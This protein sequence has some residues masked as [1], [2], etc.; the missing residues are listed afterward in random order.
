VHKL[1][2]SFKGRIQKVFLPKGITCSIGRA[3]DCDISIDNLAVEPLHA[4]IHLYEH[5]ASLSTHPENHVLINNI[6]PETFQNIELA[7]GDEITIGKHTLTYIWENEQADKKVPSTSEIQRHT[8]QSGWL[9]I[10][11]GPKMGRT[12]QLNKSS[13]QIGAASSKVA[14]ISN[15][16]DGYYLSVIDNDIEVKVDNHD[17]GDNVVPLQDGN[18]IRIG[19]MEMLFFTQQ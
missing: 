12:M 9:Q 6:K 4:T 18:T 3:P 10:M 15:R 1:I 19:E 14:L 16:E 7:Q 17:I 5:G 8:E 11:N 13:L 2:L